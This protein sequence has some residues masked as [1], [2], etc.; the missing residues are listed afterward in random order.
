MAYRTILLLATAA[1]GLAGCGSKTAEDQAAD[2]QPT[3]HEVMT[4]QID[5]RADDVWAIGNAA[6]ADTAGLDPALLD[7]ASWDKLA[8]G[9]LALQQGADT[10]AKMDPIVVARP[11]VKI[12]DEGVEN[13]SSAAEVQRNIDAEPDTLREMADVLASHAGDLAK[14]AKAHDAATAGPLI[15]QLDGVCESCHLEFWYPEQKDLVKAIIA[16]DATPAK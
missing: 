16:R 6:I 3:F 14:A 10:I 4:Q 12:L 5:A 15:N 9:A 1:I 7:D 8:A 13:G 2:T 11:G